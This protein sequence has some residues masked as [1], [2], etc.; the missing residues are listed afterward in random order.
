MSRPLCTAAVLLLVALPAGCGGDDEKDSSGGGGSASAAAPAAPSA[1]RVGISSF[2]FAPKTV[3]VE[4]GG[5]ITW[6][7]TDK[8]RHNAQT[9]DGADGAFDTGDLEKGDSKRV[10]FEE[11]GTFSYYCAYH[12]FMV[13]TVEVVQ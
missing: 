8:A 4:V 1:A 3:K 9:D 13:G 7:N 2:K 5:S 11:P 10:A 6:A 12:R